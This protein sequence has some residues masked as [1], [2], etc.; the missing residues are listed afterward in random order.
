M[1][2]RAGASSFQG[3]GPSVSRPATVVPLL[4]WRP[5][6]S[7]EHAPK[8][9]PLA[10]LFEQVDRFVWSAPG[11]NRKTRANRARTAELARAL[12]PHPTPVDVMAW[13]EQLRARFK[14]G[15]ADHHLG[16]LAAVYKYGADLGLSSGNPA[17]FV[18]KLR[19]DG[20]PRPIVNIVE[21]WP[22]LLACCETQ[23]ERLWLALLRYTGM[24]RGEALAIGADDVNTYAEPWRIEVVRQ[25][26]KPND[27]GTT[28]P[29][30][31]ASARELAV[32]APLRPFLAAVLELGPAE[33]RTG[34]GGG[35]PRVTVPWLCP[36]RENDL[37][38]LGERL[39][40]VAPLAFPRGEKMWHA[41]RDTLA[42][43]MRKGGKTTSQV[44][45][46]LGHTSEY[47]TRTHYLGAFGRSVPVSAFDGL[48][49][50]PRSGTP[51][52]AGAPPGAVGPAAESGTAAVGAAAAPERSTS[53][54]NR[55]G[56]E[57]TCSARAKSGARK[58]GGS[59]FA[60]TRERTT[61]S[62]RK[63]GGQRSES[64]GSSNAPASSSRGRQRALPG[65]AAVAVTT[66]PARAAARTPGKGRS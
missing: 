10:E 65:L 20:Q 23:R 52:R 9:L 15:T 57:A 59:A 19:R 45:E 32:R 55:A 63:A 4:G 36:F 2:Q 33:V 61:T 46:V 66:R 39:R 44:S 7:A 11:V 49:E 60:A 21:L 51:P 31:A 38:K 5:A 37:D 58:T 40:E 48:D 41:L 42:L 6:A 43:E 25:R 1:S 12:P 24:R 50:V 8:G 18:P 56:Q 26:P 17:R 3:R 29:K 16:G 53:Q 28:R 27:L 34:L 30:T 22:A 13:V 64:A 47:V 14:P 62:G 35:G 54:S